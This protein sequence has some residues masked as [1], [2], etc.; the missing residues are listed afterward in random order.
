[1]AKIKVQK[2]VSKKKKRTN[3]YARGAARE[4][5]IVNKL[6]AQGYSAVRSAGSHGLWDVIAISSEQVLL[7][8]SKLSAKKLRDDE[9]L[10]LFRAMKVPRWVFKQLY[11]FT[12]GK[13]E[14]QIEQID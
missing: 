3:Q 10:K 6:R 11:V 13:K 12:K 1:M 9:N 2:K 7:I 5:Y 14:A 4:R 8:Q